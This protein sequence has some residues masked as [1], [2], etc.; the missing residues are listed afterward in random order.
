LHLIGYRKLNAIE[1]VPD[2]FKV[3]TPNDPYP[4]NIFNENNPIP[5]SKIGNY[6]NDEFNY[7]LSIYENNKMFGFPYKNWFEMPK[8]LIDLHK[9]FNQIE[10]EFENYLIKKQK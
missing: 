4:I 8:W 5:D 3:T 9:L 2:N 7:Y 1:T 6:I 10:I